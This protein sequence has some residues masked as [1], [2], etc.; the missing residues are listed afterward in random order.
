M[1]VLIDC[2]LVYQL[3]A[4][5]PTHTHTHTCPAHVSGK[6]I[7]TRYCMPQLSI[8]YRRCS[9]STVYAMDHIYHVFHWYIC[10]TTLTFANLSLFPPVCL[11][12]C[13]SPS[14]A[15]L[16]PNCTLAWYST[17]QRQEDINSVGKLVHTDAGN[18]AE[19]LI[20]YPAPLSHALYST[21]TVHCTVQ[22]T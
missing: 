16:S 11:S 3:I 12:A 7:C 22:C 14:F 18:R 15:C 8:I 9:R 4:S 21:P 17:W 20:T 13:L 2:L 5:P 10:T 1:S 6:Y 19:L